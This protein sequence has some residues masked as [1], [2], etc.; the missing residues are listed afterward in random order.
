ME[1]AIKEKSLR[2]V[3]DKEDYDFMTDY[4]KSH[5]VGYQDFITQAIKHHILVTKAKINLNEQ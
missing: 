2:I 3:L 4:K 5:F 1:Q